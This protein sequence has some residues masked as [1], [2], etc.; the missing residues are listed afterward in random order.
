MKETNT[1]SDFRVGSA[2]RYEPGPDS[3]R[4]DAQFE[5]GNL[6]KAIWVSSY[7]IYMSQ[8]FPKQALDFTCLQCKS[9]GST[10]GKVKIACNKQFLLFP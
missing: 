7:L 8:P 1:L 10:V 5:C 2:G 3:L 9:F 6:R 4:F